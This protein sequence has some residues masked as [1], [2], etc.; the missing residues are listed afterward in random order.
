MAIKNGEIRGVYRTSTNGR[1]YAA[2]EGVP[3]AEPPTGKLRFKVSLILL[4]QFGIWSKI[5][6]F[7]NELLK[8]IFSSFI[9]IYGFNV[10]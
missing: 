1:K 2:F 4:K 3:Y 9:I 8:N 5:L 7:L 6:I 10:L